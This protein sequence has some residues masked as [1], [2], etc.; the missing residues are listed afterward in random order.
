M[1]SEPLHSFIFTMI[2]H[3]AE[4]K[5]ARKE[6]KKLLDYLKNHFADGYE[7]AEIL[8]RQCK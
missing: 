1:V 3:T 4:W 5:G 2:K 7:I 6:R 8:D